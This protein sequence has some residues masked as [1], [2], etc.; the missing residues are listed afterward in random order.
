MRMP[1]RGRSPAGDLSDPADPSW[2]SASDCVAGSVSVC[3]AT[4]SMGS[5]G[6][7]GT[8][9]GAFEARSVAAAVST[10]FAM[11]APSGRSGR[12]WFGCRRARPVRCTSRWPGRTAR[13]RSAGARAPAERRPAAGIPAAVAGM[14]CSGQGGV[15]VALPVLAV[16]ERHVLLVALAQLHGRGALARARLAWRVARA[17]HIEHRVLRYPAVQ[18]AVG[19]VGRS[20]GRTALAFAGPVGSRWCTAAEG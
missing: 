20:P 2:P 10:C 11:F 5:G 14:S 7:S 6:R 12:D 18:V 16:V 4:S 8:V 3:V 13:P 1:E 15:R 9:I 17:A 19:P